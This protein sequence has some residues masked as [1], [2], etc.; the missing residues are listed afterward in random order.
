M[1]KVSQKCENFG[2]QGEDQGKTNKFVAVRRKSNQTNRVD[3]SFGNVADR[4]APTHPDDAYTNAFIRKARNDESCD[5]YVPVAWFFLKYLP[6][7]ANRKRRR[8]TVYPRQLAPREM[9]ADFA[10]ASRAG[11]HETPAEMG[12]RPG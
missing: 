4:G 8:P 12:R 5:K 9:D 11:F 6:R 3:V 10:S 2:S 7:R 1:G